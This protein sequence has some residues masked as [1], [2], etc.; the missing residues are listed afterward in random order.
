MLAVRFGS[1][2]ANDK[3]PPIRVF[4][5]FYVAPP[6]LKRG[7]G[8][9]SFRGFTHPGYETVS[10]SGLRNFSVWIKSVSIRE[11]RGQKVKKAIWKKSTTQN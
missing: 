10:P 11:I 7:D 1:L 9:A 4:G 6:G 8:S 2:A 3:E 5:G